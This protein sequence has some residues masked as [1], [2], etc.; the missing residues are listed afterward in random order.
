MNDITGWLIA[1]VIISLYFAILLFLK[2]R[3]L[4]E[5]Y[6]LSF[7]G[8][9]LM[10]KTKKGKEFIR[11]IAKPKKFWNGFAMI[12]IVISF[13]AM[14]FMLW[15]LVENLSLLQHVPKKELQ[16]L[17]GVN[18]VVAIPCI[19]PILPVGYTII[20]LI[21]AIVVHEFSHGIQC[22]LG[23][24][25]I[26][27][28]G[29][30]AFIVPIGAF[31]EPD[32]DEL[33]NADSKRRMKVFAAGP[34]MNLTVAFLCVLIVSFIFMPSV[35]LSEGVVIYS[36]YDDS[37]A[38]SIG[39]K[40]WFVITEVNGSRIKDY[41]DFYYVMQNTTAGQNVS[42]SYRTVLGKQYDKYVVLDNKYKYTNKTEDSGIGA[43]GIKITNL[44]NNYLSIF[45]NPFAGFP[46]TFLVGYYGAP[47]MGFFIGYSPL[48]EPFTS[49]YKIEGIFSFFP[50]NVF[51]GIVNT[52]YWIFWLN[53]AVGLFN[54]LPIIPFDGGY[55][56][57][58][59]V[60]EGIKRLT[61]KIT[62]ERREKIVKVIMTA[63][64]IM[65]LFLVLAPL[66]LKYL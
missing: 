58:D 3:D 22:V 59:G 44:P 6:N 49:Y 25:K 63:I 38:E 66:I 45:R 41:R 52:F 28:L 20:G 51:W 9:L 15:L 34:T 16:N 14:F 23:K 2:K 33:K 43:I 18:M 40:S 27:S 13:I 32:E 17:P 30:I 55:I 39:L 24:I 61:R 29:I 53:F 7:Y 64:S 8:P 11:K 62:E 47:F 12:G 65:T 10:W 48:K 5:R 57:Q 36:V 19:N 4:F 31:V 60:K 37:P 46:Q 1:I 26:K 50:S 54:V 21:V 35:Q 42:I 56:L